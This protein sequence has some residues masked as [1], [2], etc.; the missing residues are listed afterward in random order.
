MLKEFF[1]FIRCALSFSVRSQNYSCVALLCRLWLSAVMALTPIFGKELSS[2]DK[3]SITCS[4]VLL[5]VA[6]QMRREVVWRASGNAVDLGQQDTNIL[7]AIASTKSNYL[8]TA[9][10]RMGFQFL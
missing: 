9:S 10:N 5:A 7:H 8:S 6:R 3:N 2:F 1:S 4:V